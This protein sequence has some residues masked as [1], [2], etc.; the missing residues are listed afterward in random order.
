[1]FFQV[2]VNEPTCVKFRAIDE[3]QVSRVHP[4]SVVVQE[5]GNP[6][7]FVKSLDSLLR[8]RQ[9]NEKYNLSLL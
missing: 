4:A 1:M 9:I 5:I 6:G 2:S 7:D 3:M 8:F